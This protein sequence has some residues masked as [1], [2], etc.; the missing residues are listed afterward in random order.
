FTLIVNVN[1]GV[2]GGTVITNRANVTTSTSETSTANNSATATT[3]VAVVAPPPTTADVSITKT[4]AAAAVQQGGQITYTIMVLNNGPG[5]ATGVNV[6]DS[7][8]AGTTF[9]SAASSQGTC[10]GT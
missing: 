4:S 9:V 6:S 1:G 5:T 8:P 10:V 2:A 3:T 7:I